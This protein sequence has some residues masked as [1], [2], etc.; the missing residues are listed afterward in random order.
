MPSCAAWSI[1]ITI[2]IKIEQKLVV[3]WER[4]GEGER[5]ASKPEQKFITHLRKII[6]LSKNVYSVVS[7]IYLAGGH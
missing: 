2:D 3:W 6:F 4:E 1:A 7:N 5:S